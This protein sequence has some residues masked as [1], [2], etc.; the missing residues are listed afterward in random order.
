MKLRDLL[1]LKSKNIKTS[2][3]IDYYDTLVFLKNYASTSINLGDVVAKFESRM[4]KKKV[5]KK[6]FEAD[7]AEYKNILKQ[8]KPDD[9]S[10][11]NTPLREYQLRLLDFSKS[12]VDDIC[13]NTDI[14]PFMVAGTLLGAIRH[15]GFIPWDDDVD[16]GVMRKD[17]NGLISYLSKKYMFINTDNWTYS[18]RD[19]LLENEISNNE[20]KI[21]TYKSP[22]GVHVIKK[23][24]NNM[25]KCDFFALDCYNKTHNITTIK[26][27][28]KQFIKFMDFNTSYKEMFERQ[29]FEINKKQDIVDDSN[30]INF[31]I[32]SY[33]FILQMP[34]ENFSKEEIYPLKEVFFENTIF[35]APQR[36]HD[37]IRKSYANYDQLPPKIRLRHTNSLI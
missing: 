8:I 37:F 20:D 3:Y 12:I 2:Q 16:F 4:T 29:A 28:S 1:G 19:K 6:Q 27:Y 35:Y 36:P 17:Y 32:D 21:I 18:T 11:E 24:K 10:V 5:S 26:N 9:I 22:Q 25:L 33:N 7:I 34:H 23:C 13:D 31:G 15:K 14:C 30:I